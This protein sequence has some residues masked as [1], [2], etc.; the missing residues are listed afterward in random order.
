MSGNGF[1]TGLDFD[2]S[3]MQQCKSTDCPRF[4]TGDACIPASIYMANDVP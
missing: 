2:D 1:S 4:L 3:K